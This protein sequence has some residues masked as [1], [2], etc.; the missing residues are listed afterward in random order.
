M[1]KELEAL[2]RGI[3]EFEKNLE[4]DPNNEWL[5]RTIAGMK[6]CYQ[7]LEA[8]ENAEPSEALEK[9]NELLNWDGA[10]KVK[11]ALYYSIKQS[12]LRAQEQEKVLEII[13]EKQV[14]VCELKICIDVYEDSLY[15]YN[16]R[17]IERFRLTPEE[18]DTLKEYFK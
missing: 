2:K 15:Q 3:I 1:S 16:K 4:D 17:T 14:D 12:L 5:K 7:R 8:I 9:L 6:K 11:F 10:S 13:F 18:F